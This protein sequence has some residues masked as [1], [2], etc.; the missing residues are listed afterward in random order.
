VRDGRLQPVYADEDVIREDVWVVTGT[1]TDGSGKSDR[2]HVEVARPASTAD[3]DI[4]LPT[5]VQA[6]PYY[7]GLNWGVQGYDMDTELY[8]PEAGP[9]ENTEPARGTDSAGASRTRR[10]TT[11][12]DE[13]LEFTGTRDNTQAVPAE[14]IGPSAYEEAFLPKGYCWAYAASIG[15]EQSTGCPTIGGPAEIRATKAVVDWFN[16]RAEAYDSPTGGA[17]VEADWTDGTTGML[18]KSYNGTL[19]NGV[20]ST[21][22]DGLEAIVPIAAISSWYS[23]YRSAGVVVTP[24]LGAT[25]GTDT[26]VLHDQVLTRSTPGVCDAVGSQLEAG[27]D[28][29]TGE[30]NEFWAE[31]DYVTD[32]AAVDAAVLVTHGLTDW[33]V[34]PRNY[35][36]WLAAL[37]AHDVPRKVW[38]TRYGHVDPIDV[39]SVESDPEIVEAVRESWLDLL[40]RWWA[41]WLHGADTGVMDDPIATVQR[42][43]GSLEQY[44]DWPAPATDSV[45][46]RPTGSGSG[47]GRLGLTRAVESPTETLVDESTVPPGTLADSPRSKHRLAYRTPQ[48][49]ERLRLSGTGR[50]R[51]AL[52]FDAPAALVSVALVRYRGDGSSTLL[53]RG[54][55][56]PQNRASASDSLPVDPGEQYRLDVD[57]Q[58]VDSVFEPGDRLGVV[59]YSSDWDF[60]RRPPS[61]PALELAPAESSVSLPVVGGREAVLAALPRPAMPVSA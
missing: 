54:W 8:V 9:G 24:G 2:V 36:R 41:H 49:R 40:D 32:A 34:K 26:R 12:E 23:Y 21:G 28:R 33:N 61:E 20:A 58:P 10:L 43:R 38:L 3:E 59:V 13:L 4:V 51:L 47:V 31:R 52:A 53:S 60:T 17:L 37:A 29:L 44:A 25:A 50:A 11:T 5:I 7:G 19:P 1:D 39:G 42:E 57:L 48:L 14:T 27:Q 35:S 30:Y 22:V 56:N 15:T 18:G 45:T 55:T 16:G 46:M 6:S